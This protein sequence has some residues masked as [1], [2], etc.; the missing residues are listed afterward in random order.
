MFCFVSFRS[1]GPLTKN[2]TKKNCNYH[3]YFYTY[4]SRICGTP[5]N[6]E[7]KQNSPKYM[8]WMLIVRFL[9][10]AMMISIIVA[11]ENEAIES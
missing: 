5:N 8:G 10:I 11:E 7:E 4:S 3:D 2:K 6:D 9:L 1:Q